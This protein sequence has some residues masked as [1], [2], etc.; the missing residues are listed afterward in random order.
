MHVIDAIETYKNSFFRK[1]ELHLSMFWE[2][3][4]RVVDGQRTDIYKVAGNSIKEL[5]NIKDD[6]G[7]PPLPHPMQAC[8][9]QYSCQK[10]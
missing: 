6:R 1:L 9:L 10:G 5:W 8:R 7:F 3:E 4:H 2:F